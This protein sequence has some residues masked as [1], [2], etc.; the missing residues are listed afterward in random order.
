MTG[1]AT[2]GANL[3][4]NLARH[5]FAVAVHNRTEARTTALVDRYGDEG[6]FVP[7]AL[8]RGVRLLAR[9]A[10]RASW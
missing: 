8:D 1:L 10:A 6:T 5:G 4:R 7:A 9:A 2:M 3:A